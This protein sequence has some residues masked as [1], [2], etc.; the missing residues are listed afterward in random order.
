MHTLRQLQTG[1]QRYVLLG[2]LF[3]FP[4]YIT[5]Q[6]KLAE[7]RQVAPHP[8]P[9][10]ATQHPPV[11]QNHLLPL[12]AR[13]QK[14][15]KIPQQGKSQSQDF[16][17]QVPFDLMYRRTLLNEVFHIPPQFFQLRLHLPLAFFPIWLHSVHREFLVLLMGRRRPLYTLAFIPLDRR[18]SLY[19]LSPRIRQA[20]LVYRVR[21]TGYTR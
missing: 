16:P 2:L 12:V 14:S 6:Q 7:H 18:N 10:Q 9:F 17:E 4:V 19:L 21:E 15:E 11:F 5:R 3:P 13:P 1:I 8:R 20:F